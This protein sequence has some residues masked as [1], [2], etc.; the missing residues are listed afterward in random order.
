QLIQTALDNRRDAVMLV[1]E[2]ALTPQMVNRFKARFGDDVAVLHSALSHGE[3]YDEWRKIQSGRARVS[4]GARSS[5]FAP[6]KNIGIIIIDEE[7]ETTY[8]QSERPM[9]HAAE[10]AKLRAAFHNCPVVLGSAT[11]SLE[12]YARSSKGVY[13][14]FELTHR[15]GTQPVPRAATV[16][17]TA[18]EQDGKRGSLPRKRQAARQERIE[19]AARTVL[20]LNRR[21]PANCQIC[22]SCGHAPKCP[23]RDISLPYHKNTST[24]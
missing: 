3:K 23:N 18:E 9:Y 15:P 5:V 1:P 11:P 19:T 24:L 22:Q 7:H 13:K 10:V 4:V 20:R 21:G 12:S 16:E 14:R 2:I 6:F 17:M 8:K